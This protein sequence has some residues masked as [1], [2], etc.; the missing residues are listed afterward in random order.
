LFPRA[1]QGLYDEALGLFNAE[2]YNEARDLLRQALM[3]NALDD[4]VTGDIHYYLGQIAEQNGDTAS[5][6]TY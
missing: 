1:A 4:A 6:R 3:Y 2:S 5:A